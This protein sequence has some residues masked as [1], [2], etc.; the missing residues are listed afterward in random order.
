MEV[1]T[2]HKYK[3]READSVIV[4]GADDRNYPLVHHTA[5]LFE[6]FGDTVDRLVDAERRLFYVATTRAQASLCYLVTAEQASPF[7]PAAVADV[8]TVVWT[9]LPAAVSPPTS[10]VVIRI[11]DAY[12]IK[13]TLKDPYGFRFDRDTETWY[14]YRPA[15]DFDFPSIRRL[16]S[17]IGPR[18]IEVRNDSNQLLHQ[19]GTR[20]SRAAI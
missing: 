2:S 4:A 3:G 19:A 13:E 10:M 14:K 20:I 9:D 7:I 12:D 15:K 5:A 11:Y 16:L 17:F 8:E 1:T 18:L 6:V